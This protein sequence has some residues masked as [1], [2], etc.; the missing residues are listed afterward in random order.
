MLSE[1]SEPGKQT[2]PWSRDD[3]P[4][5]ECDPSLLVQHE[6]LPAASYEVGSIPY[7]YH[8]YSKP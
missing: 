8:F 1:D 3:E 6:V 7:H 4:K 2:P 5:Q